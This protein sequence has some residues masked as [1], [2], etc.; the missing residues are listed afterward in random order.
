M[1]YP[2]PPLSTSNC[3]FLEDIWTSSVYPFKAPLSTSM[4]VKG[5]NNNLVHMA[6][7]KETILSF[8]PKMRKAFGLN[9]YDAFQ[10]CDGNILPIQNTKD[11][12]YVM[13]LMNSSEVNLKLLVVE[14]QKPIPVISF[15]PN[16]YK[17]GAQYSPKSS[18]LLS[19]MGATFSSNHPSIAQMYG[20]GGL[21]EN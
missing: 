15:N 11:L 4:C 2:P 17:H 3:S 1:N 7:K 9:R 13:C 5:V 20:H 14:K 16:I 19:E 6:P 18:S 8:S 10:A 12:H 21:S